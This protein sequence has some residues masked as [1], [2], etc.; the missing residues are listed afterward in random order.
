MVDKKQLEEIYKQNLENDS[1]ATKA[2]RAADSNSDLYMSCTASDNAAW[3]LYTSK[4]P[5]SFF[6]KYGIKLLQQVQNVKS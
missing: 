4:N 2:S 6:R 3:I 1:T 5:L